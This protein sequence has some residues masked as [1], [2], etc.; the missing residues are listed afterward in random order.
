ML[1]PQLVDVLFVSNHWI[2]IYFC[3]SCQASTTLISIIVVGTVG[4]MIVIDLQ[5]TCHDAVALAH[6]YE[7]FFQQTTYF[8]MNVL[9]RLFFLLFVFTVTVV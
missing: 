9:H 3:Q 8:A 6:V 4:M 2:D 5:S 1:Q 7:D